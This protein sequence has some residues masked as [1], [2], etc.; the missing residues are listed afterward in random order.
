MRI[1]FAGISEETDFALDYYYTYD[2]DH[3]LW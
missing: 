2:L 1:E 3:A